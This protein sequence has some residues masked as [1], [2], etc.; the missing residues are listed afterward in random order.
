MAWQPTQPTTAIAWPRDAASA[1]MAVESKGAREEAC[2]TA[3]GAISVL[4][5]ATPA[6][7]RSTTSETGEILDMVGM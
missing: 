4:Q 6:K 1:F 5:D 3:V 2:V 7:T